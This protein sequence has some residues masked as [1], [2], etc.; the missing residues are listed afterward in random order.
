MNFSKLIII[1]SLLFSINVNAVPAVDKPFLTESNSW[2]E[3]TKGCGM[4]GS[5]EVYKIGE[6]VA[7]NQKA[8]DEYEK[9]GGYVHD[10]EAVLM[11]CQYIVN[12]SN[13]DH[14]DLESRKYIWVSFSW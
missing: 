2:L 6:L 3:D 13:D 10:G 14:P 8:I 11:Q 12:P 1:F 4:D 7:M 9:S 5:E